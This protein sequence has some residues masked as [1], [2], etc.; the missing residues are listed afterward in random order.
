MKL[1]DLIKGVPGIL[2]ETNR[3]KRAIVSL[4]A[5][6]V[7][8]VL[9]FVGYY[10]WDRYI[11]LGDESP[12]EKS[13]RELEKAV[14][15]HPQD[16][17]LRLALAET[18]MLGARYDKAG[19]Q[20]A[21]V[22]K[23]YPDNE[24]AMF[25][26]GV[27]YASQQEWEQAIGPLEQFSSLRSKRPTAGMDNLLETALYYLGKSHNALGRY[28][29]AIPALSQAVKINPTDADS[30]YELGVAY[31]RAGEF[32]KAIQSYE[33]AV[34]FVPNF[35]EAYQGMVESYTALNQPKYA[36]YARGMVY[37]SSKD[38]ASARN[39]LEKAVQELPDYAP[40]FIGLGLACEELGDLLSAEVNFQRAL[41]I[42][43]NNFTALQALGR[44]QTKMQSR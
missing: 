31:A 2:A 32:E 20:A 5:V 7:L 13:V 9:A 6:L 14:S 24:R 22:L 29:D 19:E 10:Y 16:V 28:T 33:N 37:F 35:L 1:F 26:L 41:Q 25:I 39:E 34:R 43:P 21:Q 23:A 17:E 36:A 40:A 18:Y 30:F 42:D 12:V 3:L 11:H 15:Q 38:Y 44:V 4:A 8:S 27:S